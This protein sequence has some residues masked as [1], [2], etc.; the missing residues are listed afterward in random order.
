MRYVAYRV[1]RGR[2]L[3]PDGVA[4]ESRTVWIPEPELFH[5]KYTGL[6][7]APNLQDVEVR[8]LVS[9]FS[10]KASVET[11]VDN[12]FIPNRLGAQVPVARQ[13][14]HDALL[15]RNIPQQKT[16]YLD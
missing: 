2:R 9:Q 10:Q 12:V 15:H 8:I 11:S 14:L 13:K 3:R 16:V 1:E 7:I 5:G 6:Q 4:I